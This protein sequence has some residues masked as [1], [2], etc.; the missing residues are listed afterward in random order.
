MKP[1]FFPQGN[2]NLLRMSILSAPGK[3]DPFFI[4]RAIEGTLLF[5]TGFSE[6]TG[7]GTTYTAFP[8]MRLPYSE[9]DRLL[10]WVLLVPGFDIQ[11]FQM[12]LETL[13]F[14]HVYGTREVI[15]YI[16][17]SISDTTFLDR[18][19]FFELFSSGALDR[20]IGNFLMRE[21]DGGLSVSVDS[22][23]IVLPFLSPVKTHPSYPVLTLGESYTLINLTETIQI[24][25]GEIFDISKRKVFKHSLKFTFDTFYIDKNSVGIA[26]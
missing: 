5:G 12:I 4:I 3:S 2:D 17:D 9:K 11:A 24:A 18:C 16:R 10:G 13:G 8:D 7:A 22:D 20:K 19:R 1:S 26:L 15:A 23:G 14:P 25:P 6:I 21:E